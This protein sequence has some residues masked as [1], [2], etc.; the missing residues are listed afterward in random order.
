[1]D[2]GSHTRTHADLTAISL[3]K[4]RNEIT[5]SKAELENTIGCET[6]H[7]CY[8]YG[9]FTP[10]HSAITKAAGFITAT[11]TQRGR[12]VAGDDLYTLRR[13]LI[14]RSTNAIQFL[15]KIISAYED[16]RGPN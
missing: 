3:D 16:R 14:A 13:V 4:A 9:L 7:F 5:D 8:P 11:T 6:R 10:P 15:V 2:I 1:M 12:V